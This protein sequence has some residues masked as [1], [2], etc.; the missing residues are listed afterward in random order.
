[1]AIRLYAVSR[2]AIVMEQVNVWGRMVLLVIAA[3]LGAETIGVSSPATAP[4]PFD[5]RQTLGESGD[6]MGFASSPFQQAEVIQG[7]QRW[8]F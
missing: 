5:E 2:R 1:M 3:V 6:G 7:G 4:T 8:V